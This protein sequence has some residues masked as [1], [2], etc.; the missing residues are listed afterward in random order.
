MTRVDFLMD[1]KFNHEVE[2][3]IRNKRPI[4]A[5][6]STVIAHGLPYPQNLETAIRLEQIVRDS[7]AVPATV[8][9]F[10]GDLCV[11]LDDGQIEKLA[12]DKNIRKIS[13]RDLPIAAA[14]R[15]TCATTVATTLYAAH[16]ARI[17]VFATGG[18]GGIHRGCPADVSADLPMLAKTP[19]ITVCA[20]AKIVLDLVSTR[21]WLETNGVTVLGF[22]CDE[23]PAFYSRQS[24]LPVDQRV[25][26]FEEIHAIVFA[27]DVLKLPAAILLTVPIPEESEIELSELE[28]VLEN[29]LRLAESTDVSGKE[30]TPFLLAELSRMTDGKTLS[31]NIALLENNARIAAQIALPVTG[32]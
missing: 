28:P 3:A 7:D 21:E 12:T 19:V 26:T 32:D 10:D 13:M 6:E 30:I 9:M 25:E 14:G 2:S 29:A 31:A 5:L 27:R 20:G 1:L 11:G 8:A 23:I 15:M 24:G 4:V 17:R 18:I 16:R 22:R